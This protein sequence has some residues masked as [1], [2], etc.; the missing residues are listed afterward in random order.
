LTEQKSGQATHF[1]AYK[2]KRLSIMTPRLVY[3][4]ATETVTIDY[5]QTLRLFLTKKEHHLFSA[6]RMLRML[7]GWAKISSATLTGVGRC[8]IALAEGQCVLTSQAV[9]TL[10]RLYWKRS[11]WQIEY[12]F[13]VDVLGSEKEGERHAH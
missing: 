8:H 3:T 10:S 2:K 9:T 7:N 1:F 4:T 11:D 6:E 12:P 13:V 5:D